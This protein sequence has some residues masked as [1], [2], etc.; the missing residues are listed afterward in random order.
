MTS[1]KALNEEVRRKGL[2]N[3]WKFEEHRICYNLYKFALNY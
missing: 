1:I 2:T 3:K